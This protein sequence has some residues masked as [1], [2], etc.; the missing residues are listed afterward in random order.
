MFA[1]TN[2]G[3]SDSCALITATPPGPVS[4]SRH[5]RL[6]RLPVPRAGF[7]DQ[8]TPPPRPRARYV[9]PSGPNR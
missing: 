7:T 1:W 9:E 8:N 2:T 4:A 3:R 5:V 6:S